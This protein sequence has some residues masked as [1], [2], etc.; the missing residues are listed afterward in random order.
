MTNAVYIC[1]S[2]R[3]KGAV[4]EASEDGCVCVLQ[5]CTVSVSQRRG[6]G[7]TSCDAGYDNRPRTGRSQVSVGKRAYENE[8]A[9]PTLLCT[10]N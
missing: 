3:H 6:Q 4:V 7:I 1:R 10:Y 8:D 9:L 5:F 2:S